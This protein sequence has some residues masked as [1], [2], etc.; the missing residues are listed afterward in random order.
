MIAQAVEKDQS[1]NGVCSKMQ[2]VDT[3]QVI[4]CVTSLKWV[5]KRWLELTLE[6][7]KKLLFVRPHVYGAIL[8]P[9]T[10]PGENNNH[11]HPPFSWSRGLQAQTREKIGGPRPDRCVLRMC[12][13]EHYGIFNVLTFPDL[14][15]GKK[16]FRGWFPPPPQVGDC[17]FERQK[18]QTSISWHTVC[19]NWLSSACIL[20]REW[21]RTYLGF[22][23]FAF[24]TFQVSRQNNQAWQLMI[25]HVSVE[26]FQPQCLSVSRLETISNGSDSN[27]R[28]VDRVITKYHTLVV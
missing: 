3:A 11:M 25:W 14:T 10:L 8:W 2:C 13:Q 5:S 7:Q 20:T 12:S 27:P 1:V 16:R 26:S 23:S 17:M 6:E 18:V 21:Q 4:L 24:H 9:A 28:L 15:L 19:V 22:K